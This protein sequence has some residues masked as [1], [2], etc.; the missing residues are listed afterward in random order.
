MP[1]SILKCKNYDVHSVGVRLGDITNFN[2]TAWATQTAMGGKRIV[3]A[4][5]KPDYTLELVK[6][7][8]FFSLNFLSEDQTR[9]VAKLGRSSGRDGNKLKGLEFAFDPNGFP[10]LTEA[11]GY[12]NC[13][14]LDWADGGDHEIA[15]CEVVAQK[16]L[17]PQK[18]L[19]TLNYL[20]EKKLIRG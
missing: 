4:L 20:R 6:A 13:R 11:F 17:H 8:Q 14:V 2:I 18:K 12:A 5:H 1:R 15:I 3:V 10:Y 19:L 7:S 9:L 16:I